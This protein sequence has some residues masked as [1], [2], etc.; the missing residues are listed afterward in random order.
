[1]QMWGK[2]DMGHTWGVK[3]MWDNIIRHTLGIYSN[4][5]RDIILSTTR[6]FK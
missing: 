2:G 5:I 1:M 3:G 6:A 4:N